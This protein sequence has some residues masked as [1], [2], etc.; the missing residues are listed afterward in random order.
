MGWG[1]YEAVPTIPNMG[2]RYIR[3]QRK[4]VV[5][6]IRIGDKMMLSN[7]YAEMWW[8]FACQRNVAVLNDKPTTCTSITY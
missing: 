3:K 2:M 5:N 8:V 7:M 6:L 4:N 1:Y